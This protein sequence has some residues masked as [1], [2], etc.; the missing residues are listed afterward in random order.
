M[1]GLQGLRADP[2]QGTG[3]G[4][5][6]QARAPP[7]H[8]Q[9]CAGSGRGRIF[10]HAPA[11]GDAGKARQGA[12]GGKSR[13][14]RKDPEG[15]NPSGKMIVL[16]TGATGFIG[17]SLSARLASQGHSLRI[18][19]RNP[20]ATSLS[21][22]P[23][24][25]VA[26][27]WPAGSPVPAAAV[28][29]ADAVVHLAGENIGQWPWT[30]ARKRRIL[31]SRVQGT[32]ALVEAL[33]RAHKGGSGSG[34]P[35]VLVSASAVGYYGDGGDAL[36]DES[37]P[38]GNGFLAEVCAAWE[39]ETFRARELGIRTVAVRNG[40]VLGRGGALGKLLPVYRL[41]GGAVLGSGGQWWSWA[42]V[43]D[44]AGIFAH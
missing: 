25:T 42:H 5:L 36:L 4:N 20:N 15:Q 41:G 44:T 40:L 23:A 14:G 34:K 35:S 10:H 28:D 38:P 8:R 9:R 39:W 3:K 27:A 12:Q 31:D 2:G 32:R 21:A 7:G 29:G 16:V 37:R 30:A 26:F 24:G 13:Q 18:L 6:V 22:L 11:R 19:S 17:R 33:G 43:E 1:P